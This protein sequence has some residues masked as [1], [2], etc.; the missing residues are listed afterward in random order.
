EIHAV[1]SEDLLYFAMECLE[2]RSVRDAL[3]Q[4]PD[5]VDCENVLRVVADCMAHCHQQGI[6]HRDLK[7]DNVFLLADGRVKLI[8]FGVA[9]A[10]GGTQLTATGEMVGTLGY[11]APE[12]FGGGQPGPQTDVFAFGVMAFEMYAGRMPFAHPLSAGPVDPPPRMPAHVAAVM[13]RC[14]ARDPAERYTDFLQVLR[15]LPAPDGPEFLE[16]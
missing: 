7:S 10:V 8:D 15:D 5:G 6:L 13:M 16:I 3:R 12:L 14:L 4:D 9:R 1:H 11:L 2:G